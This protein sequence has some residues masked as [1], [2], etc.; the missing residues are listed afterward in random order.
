MNTFLNPMNEMKDWLSNRKEM[1]VLG[2]RSH[3]CI[4]RD[5]VAL[6]HGWREAVLV[7]FID[8]SDKKQRHAFQSILTAY[9][10]EGHENVF[11]IL[12]YKEMQYF[13]VIKAPLVQRLKRRLASNCKE[14]LFVDVDAHLNSPEVSSIETRRAICNALFQLIEG[15]EVSSE[16][17][18]TIQASMLISLSAILLD[19]SCAYV[20]S[21]NMNRENDFIPESNCLSDIPL[22]EISVI[23][24]NTYTTLFAYTIPS[25]MFELEKVVHYHA[26]LRIRHQLKQGKIVL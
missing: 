1:G 19:Y 8:L 18:L 22:V 3:H 6:I 5:L 21:H 17:D 16:I 11:E 7:D 4:A 13:I 2:R 12:G 15:I 25:S 24:P 14:I 23:A 26:P 10:T 20:F 9:N